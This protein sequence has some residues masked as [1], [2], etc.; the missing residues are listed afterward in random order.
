MK[1]RF[2]YRNAG[3]HIAFR[4]AS[5]RVV[6]PRDLDANGNPPAWAVSTPI[7][8]EADEVEFDHKPT[9]AEL[10]VAFPN[11]TF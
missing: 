2:L 8:K 9:D 4:D 5:E 10:A 7:A 6:D 11:L 3:D 1:V